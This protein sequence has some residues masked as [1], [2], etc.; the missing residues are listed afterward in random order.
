MVVEVRIPNMIAET[1]S[2]PY[3][4]VIFTSIRTDEDNGYSAM[5][6][7][8]LKLAY[9]QPAFLGV[10]RS[11][12]ITVSYWKDTDSIQNWKVDMNHKTAQRKGKSKWYESYKVRISKVERD[13]AFIKKVSDQTL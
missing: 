3:Y 5:N 10:E 7:L 13:Y 8:M 12:G 2:P 11:T 1:P 4:A 9:K 6:D